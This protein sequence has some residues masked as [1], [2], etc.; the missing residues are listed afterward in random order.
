VHYT[1]E[2]FDL[3]K[4]YSELRRRT[5]KITHVVKARRVWSIKQAR[6]QLELLLGDK[7]GDWVGLD[8]CLQKYLPIADFDKPSDKTVVA[9]S[10]GATLEM[11]REGVVELKQDEPFAPIYMRKREAGAEWQRVEITDA[12]G[13]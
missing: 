13:A 6:N 8:D 4:A 3:L 2:I 11:A 5:V 7:V 10:F 12:G 1:A 9:S